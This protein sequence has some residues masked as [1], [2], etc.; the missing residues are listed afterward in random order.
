MRKLRQKLTLQIVL[1]CSRQ[2]QRVAQAEIQCEVRANFPIVLNERRRGV[3]AIVVRN[4]HRAL[5]NDVRNSKQITGKR[6]SAIGTARRTKLSARL[7]YAE[8]PPSAGSSKKG[9]HIQ[10]GVREIDTELPIHRAAAEIHDIDY[11]V[12]FFN[13]V[14]VRG[15]R[16]ANI[17][18][19]VITIAVGIE[20][21]EGHTTVGE[22]R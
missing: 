1:F 18:E 8:I 14:V 19:R 6:I 4:Q 3:P 5:Q 12:A 17:R 11:V 13:V 20:E 21:E 10:K 2:L 15:R 9:N 7:P 16:G 22:T